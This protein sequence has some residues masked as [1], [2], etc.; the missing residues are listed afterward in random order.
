MSYVSY[1][2]IFLLVQEVLRNNSLEEGKATKLYWIV[3]K[4][5]RSISG[6]RSCGDDQL[7]FTNLAAHL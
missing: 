3:Q 5:E 2:G 4:G 1:F 7:S 6:L